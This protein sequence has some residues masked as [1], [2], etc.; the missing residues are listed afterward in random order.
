MSIDSWN[1]GLDDYALGRPMREH[2]E[3]YTSGYNYARHIEDHYANRQ[4]EPSFEE[5]QQADFFEEVEKA[6]E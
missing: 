1:R 6:D 5:L 4:P 2:G 3:D